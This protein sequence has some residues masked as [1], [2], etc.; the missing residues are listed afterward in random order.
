M[1]VLFIGLSVVDVFSDGGGYFP[2]LV[3]SG[4]DSLKKILFSFFAVLILFFSVVPCYAGAF[5]GFPVVVQDP[6]EEDY[7]LDYEILGIDDEGN[8]ILSPEDYDDYFNLMLCDRIEHGGIQTYSTLPE[9]LDVV[10]QTIFNKTSEFSEWLGDGV[11]GY[12]KWFASNPLLIWNWFKNDDGTYNETGDS[13]KNE[14]IVYP[15]ASHIG[16]K[17]VYYSA[18]GV[19]ENFSIALNVVVGGGGYSQLTVTR[20]GFGASSTFSAEAAGNVSYTF[21]GQRIDIRGRCTVTDTTSSGTLTYTVGFCGYSQNSLPVTVT[22]STS[23]INFSDSSILGR[24]NAYGD[25]VYAE[26][27]FSTNDYTYQA[28]HTIMYNS[29]NYW[30]CNTFMSP[31]IS[32][33]TITVNNIGDFSPY[34]FY[35]NPEG[36]IGLNLGDLN[37]YLEGNLFPELLALYEQFF[38]K[39]P[40][41]DADINDN[42]INYFNPFEE[43]QEATETFPPATLPPGGSSFDFDYGEVISPS[44][45]QDILDQETYYLAEL[46]TNH[47]DFKLDSVPS[48]Q[49]FPAEIISGV[50]GL[51]AVYEKLLST[52]GV[53]SVFS[54]I[55]VLVFFIRVFRG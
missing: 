47:F 46:D 11:K 15:S 8:F 12:G 16:K 10:G 32:G 34:G 45:L 4:G 53:L 7:Y 37:A 20:S 39:F 51:G 27:T 35:I 40:D 30:K 9:I 44:E 54:I 18:A 14:L 36:N 41:I 29:N 48:L 38:Q 25:A 24:S 43:D 5:S 2:L 55:A 23:A 33:N 1:L 49:D 42:D 31:I 52:S 22:G 28:N 17:R 3:F 19:Y 26:N 6:F 21:T 50:T 13:G